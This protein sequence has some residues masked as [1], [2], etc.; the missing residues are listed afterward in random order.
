M[1]DEDGY[2]VGVVRMKLARD[3][4]SAGAG[5]AV[6]VNVVKDF[7]EAN[8]LLER[9]PVV[10]LRPG[11]RHLARLEADRRRAAGRLPRPLAGARRW[12]TRA[13]S[14]E[15][16]F[17]VDRW[18]TPWPAS[19]LEEALL[20]GRGRAGLRAGG[21]RRRV[22]ASR[23]SAGPPTALAAG[24]PAE[25]DRV[26][27]GH[28]RAGPALSRRVRDRGPRPARRWSRATWAPPTPSPS[29]S[30]SCAAR[31]E[32]WRPAPLLAEPAAAVRCGE[33]GRRCSSR[34]RS[35]TERGRVV[36]PRALV[37]RAG[38]AGRLRGAAAGGRR[39]ARP[40][41]GRLH[42]RAARA[43]LAGQAARRSARS[44]CAG[45]GA[46]GRIERPASARPA[47]AFRVDRL[48]VPVAVRGRA[49][50]AQGRDA[51]C[52]SSRRRSRSCRSS[53]SS[54]P[55]GQAGRG[56][57]VTASGSSMKPGWIGAMPAG[58]RSRRIVAPVGDGIL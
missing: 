50:A 13:R 27:R 5:F 7:L 12:P 32:A 11:V 45:S 49:R 48:G 20:G 51:C 54:T 16:G 1:L 34:P 15:I 23:A 31:C 39:A 33:P 38:D 53:R 19:G 56:D 55:L 57:A 44:R 8:G 21:R 6:P 18:E 29:T 41:S 37:A 3:A 46:G 43:A 42:A 36:V 35:R 58:P 30:G 9:L 52:S 17:R 4:T 10:R 47:Y 25:P 26:G 14:G 40:P 28:G 24:R 2:V 22:R